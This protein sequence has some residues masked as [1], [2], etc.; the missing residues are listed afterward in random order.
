LARY[1]HPRRPRVFCGIIT[2]Q[3]HERAVHRVMNNAKP[4]ALVVSRAANEFAIEDARDDHALM[5]RGSFILL[6]GNH[7]AGDSA[8]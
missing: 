5:N 2:A 3:H 4:I 7:L 1:A 8:N 6:A